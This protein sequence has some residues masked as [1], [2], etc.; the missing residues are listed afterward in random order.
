MM[1]IGRRL[2]RTYVF[3]L[4][5]IGLLA[6]GGSLLQRETADAQRQSAAVSSIVYDQQMLV[7]RIAKN[8]LALTHQ[9]PTPGFASLRRRIALDVDELERNHQVLLSGALERGVLATDVPVLSQVLHRE[10]YRLDY[11]I[12]RY[13]AATREM[14]ATPLDRLDAVTTEPIVLTAQFDLP[15]ALRAT[16]RAYDALGQEGIRHIEY[17]RRLALGTLLGT[18]L[19]VGLLGFR[20]IVRRVQSG[21]VALEAARK[22]MEHSALHDALTALPNRRYL[23]E[24]LSTAMARGRRT[25][26]TVALLHLDLDKFKQ[27]NDTYGHAAGDEVLVTAVMRMQETVRSSDFLARVGGDEFIIV[28]TDVSSTEGLAI[29]A[30]RLIERMCDYLEWNGNDCT[31]GVSIGIAIAHPADHMTEERL[32]MNAD[33]A[34]YAAKDG[35]RST[36]RFFGNDGERPL[37][38][39]AATPAGDGGRGVSLAVVNG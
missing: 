13:A 2:T 23:A 30:D 33:H 35:G 31:I 20:P 11:K 25:G 36:F 16:T 7:Q 19:M 5:L 28:T 32:I 37:P 21:V 10:P 9:T 26:Q 15:D 8:T 22:R 1:N 4:A 29:L 14:L 3:A 24:H 12:R 38:Q 6:V 18:L 17:T 27:V 34:L 39:Q